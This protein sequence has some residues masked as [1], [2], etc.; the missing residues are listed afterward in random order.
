MNQQLQ[1]AILPGKV[2]VAEWE[3]TKKRVPQN[4]VLLEKALAQDFSQ[5]CSRALFVLGLSDLDTPLSLS[6][7]YWRDF[8]QHYCKQVL[9]HPE[10]EEQRD[11]LNIKLSG[12]SRFLACAPEMTGL[13]YLD[14][15]LL[16]SVW[17]ELHAGYRQALKGHNGSVASLFAELTPQQH[18][19]GRI[20]FHLVENKKQAVFPFAFLATYSTRVDTFGRS[21]HLPL[22]YA[23]REY[24]NDQSKLLELMVAIKRIAKHS[25]LIKELSDTGELFE[26]IGLCAKEA[27][28]FLSEV[29]E[30]E[31]AG[32]L[33]RI[34]RWWSGQ[35]KA[36][37]VGLR[38]GEKSPGGLGLEALLNFK[39]QL[40]IDGEPI[41]LK[42][43][44]ALLA[45]SEGLAL[46]KGK[47][48]NVDHQALQHSLALL[49][50]A[51][52]L[53]KREGITVAEAMRLLMGQRTGL[54]DELG[55]EGVELSSGQWLSR[56][57]EKMRDPALVR[58]IKPSPRFKATLR[59][60]QQHGLNWLYFLHG[61]GLGGCLADDMGL[62]KTIQVLAFLQLIKDKAKSPQ[63]SLLLVPTSLMANWIHE[64]KR[65]AP[66]LRVIVAHN[67][68]GAS[69]EQLDALPESLDRYDLV[70]STYGMAARLSWLAEARW[71]YCIL[72]EAQAIKNPS[73]RQT[74]AVKAI[75]AER[76]LVLTGTPIENRL[77]DLWSLFDFLNPG[78]LGSQRGFAKLTQSLQQQPE[79]YG[80]LRQVISPY[81]LRRMKSDKS[82]IADLPDKIEV[83]AW[84]SLS[85]K[86][87]VLYKKLVSEL[88]QEISESEG[89]QR[90]GLVLSYLIK[91]KQLCNHP[92][93]YL[94]SGD[95]E[96]KHSGK[97]AQLREIAQTIADKR[98][99]VLVFTQFREM[100]EPLSRF[101]EQVFSRPGLVLH[102]GSTVKQRNAMVKAF[103]NDPSVPFFVLSVK[104]GGVGLNL[105]AANHVVHFDRWWNP[106]IE[107]Q[108]TDR[109]FRIG[110]E[111]NV[112]VH[113]FACE[114]TVEEKIDA[115]IESKQA[116]S[117]RIIQSSSEK[118]LTELDDTELVDL[119][120][121]DMKRV[122][123]VING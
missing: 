50:K 3:S 37:R 12:Q 91:F 113:K 14:A 46:I 48:V 78:L 30:Y 118:W 99:K 103:Q 122:E 25:A 7:G 77:T 35:A 73:T 33:C 24:Q 47:W 27:H 93:H 109:A 42:E 75:E 23:F 104:A 38:V 60:Y 45:Q 9:A 106:A 110:Q 114:G 51:Q 2:L 70:I 43:A 29:P 117:E 88:E 71:H 107:N 68:G 94:G 18:L 80:R 52:A 59:P 36:V 61:L 83:K 108:A 81:I 22:Q 11:K 69:R 90:R 5:N 8:A 123:E 84:P 58:A 39:A 31:A 53:V 32:V 102:G 20:H 87:L 115:L 10:V 85:K 64:I 17:L 112:M 96:E 21:R 62:G 44:K 15:S 79:G 76:R 97:F 120:R 13:E 67:Q 98:E 95:Y 4:Q 121:L 119:F 49:K 26:P 92:D 66:S 105:T 111:R 57:W 101:L 74:R 54:L 56:L 19:S 6:L 100:T 28:Q 72:D 16:E 41:S 89:M 40:Q 55:E 1:I 86:Q 65:F 34:P 63:C 82:I 116:L